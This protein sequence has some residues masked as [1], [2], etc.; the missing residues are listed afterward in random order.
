[1]IS[2]YKWVKRRRKAVALKIKA[3][4]SNRCVDIAALLKI[5]YLTPVKFAHDFGCALIRLLCL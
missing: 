1:M 4:V 3:T 2:S 5:E